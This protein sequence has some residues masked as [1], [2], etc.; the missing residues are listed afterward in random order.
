[1]KSDFDADI[2]MRRARLERIVTVREEA[3]GRRLKTLKTEIDTRLDIELVMQRYALPVA[4]TALLAGF[5]LGRSLGK[6]RRAQ[7]EPAQAMPLSTP[8]NKSSR[9]P[10]F[11]NQI[12]QTLLESVKSLA[13]NYAAEFATR[14]LQE[15]LTNTSV[16]K[17]PLTTTSSESH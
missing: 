17:A 8:Q 6:P 4:G 16:Q 15:W 2:A 3:I 1:M 11:L 9:S 13:L 12:A 14:K 7:H 10:K 5:L